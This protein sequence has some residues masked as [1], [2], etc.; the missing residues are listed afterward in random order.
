MR[1]LNQETLDKMEK[2]IVDYQRATVISM[3]LSYGSPTI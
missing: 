2:Y 1:T 3:T